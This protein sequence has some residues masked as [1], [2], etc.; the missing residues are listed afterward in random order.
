MISSFTGPGA[1]AE[2]RHRAE[3]HIDALFA[4]QPP[5]IPKHGA[6][7]CNAEFAAYRGPSLIVRP[8]PGGV[9]RVVDDGDLV[10]RNPKRTGPCAG[11]MRRDRDIAVEPLQAPTVLAGEI[12]GDREMKLADRGHPAETSDGGGV[13]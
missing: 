1:G 10:L 7:V 4:D 3:Q 11:R 13:R 6:V 2:A 12:V 8:K 9:D 5:A